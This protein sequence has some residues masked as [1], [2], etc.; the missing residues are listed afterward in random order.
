MLENIK[1]LL[2]LSS[3]EK[4]ALLNLLIMECSDEAL[5][6]THRK[7]T[8]DLESVIQQMVIY[9]YNRLGTEGLNSESY[10]GTSYSYTNDYPEPIIR[11]L[12]RYR[13]VVSL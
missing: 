4:D 12:K 2:G 13:K 7:D 9:K 11:M 6:F 8:C 3:S 10:S 1:L 5:D